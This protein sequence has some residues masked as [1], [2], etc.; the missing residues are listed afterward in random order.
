[1]G[2]KA[3]LLEPQCHFPRYLERV[4]QSLARRINYEIVSTSR[5]WFR[6]QGYQIPAD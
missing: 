1:M 2:R 6:H 3:R 5:S 4:Q